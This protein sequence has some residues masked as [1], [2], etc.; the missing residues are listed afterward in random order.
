MSEQTP[1]SDDLTP[2]QVVAM[3]YEGYLH[4][5]RLDPAWIAGWH[6]AINHAVRTLAK[7][8]N[9]TGRTGGAA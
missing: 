1:E 4:S 6:A 9:P 3:E 2:A 5:P 7:H 8:S